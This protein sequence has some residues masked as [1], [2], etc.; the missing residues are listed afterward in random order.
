MLF[1]HF[2]EEERVNDFKDREIGAFSEFGS[3]RMKDLYDAQIAIT[4]LD[5][6][7]LEGANLVVKAANERN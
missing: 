4:K 5:G 1:G 6:T 2:G 3:V 7:R